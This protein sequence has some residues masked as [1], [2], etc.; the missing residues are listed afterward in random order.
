[1]KPTDTAHLDFGPI[2]SAVHQIILGNLDVSFEGVRNP[3]LQPLVHALREMARNLSTEFQKMQSV[4]ASMRNLVESLPVALLKWSLRGSVLLANPTALSLW[5]FSSREQIVAKKIQDVFSRPEELKHLMQGVAEN[6]AVSD[7]EI[8]IQR[9]D[10][11]ERLVSCTAAA[12][13]DEDKA[14]SGFVAAFRDIRDQRELETHLI[15]IEK[16]ESIGRFASGLAHDLNNILCGILPNIEI[17]RRHLAQHAGGSGCDEKELRLL[18]SI[19]KSAQRGVTLAKQLMSFSR[20]SQANMAVV[21]L[22]TIVMDCLHNLKQSLGSEIR[23]ET[24]LSSDLWNIEADR[25]QIEEILI[26]LSK[27]AEDAMN[28]SGV[29]KMS[30]RNFKLEARS[31]ARP[32]G[33]ESGDYVQLI[34]SDSGRG[35]TPQDLYHIF[36]PFFDAEGTGKGVGLSLSLVFG[37]VKNHKGSIEVESELHVGSRFIIHL[38]RTKKGQKVFEPSV[39]PKS[40]RRLERILVVDDEALVREAISG[41]LLELGYEVHTVQD[42]DEALMRISQG[43][44]FDLV[45]LDMQMPRM[46]GSQT[47]SRLREINPNLKIVLTSGHFPPENVHGLLQRYRCGFLQKPFR[48]AEISKV[49]RDTLDGNGF[50]GPEMN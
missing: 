17:F 27:N 44:P 28:G 20:K 3:D 24:D 18:D 23:I 35:I 32:R 26:H 38:P 46:D 34:V 22:N 14:V 48:L 49:V 41:L 13:R 19:E 6:G 5:G 4:S 21:N 2:V 11:E 16:L 12:L 29:L 8:F 39:Q 47:L 36:D 10:G 42:G 7:F 15:Q 9:K 45:I 30:T 31:S 1:M 37:M 25:S 43:D 33:L 40:L 50:S